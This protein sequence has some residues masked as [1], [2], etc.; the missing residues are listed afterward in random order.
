MLDVWVQSWRKEVAGGDVIMVR[1]ADDFVLGFQYQDDAER[2]LRELTERFREHS[3]ELHP[4]KTRLIRFGRNA[5]RDCKHID[6][7]RKP[8]TFNFLGFTHSCGLSRKG[9][10]MLK[11]TTM[12][13]RLTAKQATPVGVHQTL[14]K[15]TLL[16]HQR[17]MDE[18][19]ICLN[20]TQK[21]ARML[22]Y[23]ARKFI[24][25]GVMNG[26][27]SGYKVGGLHQELH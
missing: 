8:E 13:K 27:L 19:G 3:L 21:E 15:R 11:R 1:W 2:F 4:E 20:G 18:A 22:F 7:K 9:R 23:R 26:V 6:G 25:C 12:R 10:S 24:L 5:R 16:S 17:R 14:Q